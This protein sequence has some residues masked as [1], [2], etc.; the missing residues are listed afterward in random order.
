MK[1]LFNANAMSKPLKQLFFLRKKTF[2]FFCF[3]FCVFNLIIN[4]K[5]I[6]HTEDKASLDRCG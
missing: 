3:K 1:K 2:T 6:P 4:K 5:K